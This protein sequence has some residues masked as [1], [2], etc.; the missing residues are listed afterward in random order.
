MS[1]IAKMFEG[2]LACGPV[3]GCGVAPNLPS[4]GRHLVLKSPGRLAGKKPGSCREKI[5]SLQGKNCRIAGK[6]FAAERG[7]CEQ[8]G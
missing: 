7:H 3:S 1:E 4:I 5:R 2:S 8:G 6:K